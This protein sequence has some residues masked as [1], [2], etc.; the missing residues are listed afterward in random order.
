MNISCSL[1][2]S[3]SSY[4]S[5][6]SNPFDFKLRHYPDGERLRRVVVATIGHEDGRLENSP[7]ALG[8][9][10]HVDVRLNN[11]LLD[12]S[13]V[14]DGWLVFE[15]FPVQLAVGENLLGVRLIYG[16]L[17]ARGEVLVEKLEIHVNRRMN[18]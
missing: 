9:E 12:I 11:A 18:S 15:A 10:E 2:R 1:V 6:S 3:G 13:S 7:P 5:P 16:D 4:Y 17:E 8:I 14:D